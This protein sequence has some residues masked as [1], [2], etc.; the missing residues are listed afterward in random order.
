[1][2]VLLQSLPAS[3][4]ELLLVAFVAVG[5]V[6]FFRACWRNIQADRRDRRRMAPPHLT[7]SDPASRAARGDIE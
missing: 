4:L 3:P 2:S 1:M 6:L 7:D 5:I